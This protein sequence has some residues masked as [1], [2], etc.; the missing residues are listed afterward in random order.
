MFSKSAPIDKESKTLKA[1]F[2][3]WQEEGTK[4]AGHHL[5]FANKV[6]TDIVKP[7]ESFLKSKETERKKAIGEGQKRHKQ[8]LDAKAN[9]EKSKDVY[10]K[11]MKEAEQATEAHEKAKTDLESGPDA[12]KK[13]LTENEKKAAQK[14][15]QLTEKGKA[16]EAAY[17]KAVDTAND[18]AK[19]TFGTH[20]PPVIDS[21][22]ALEE[23]RYNL[24]KQVLETFQKEFR[25]L[26]DQLIERADELSKA[27]EAL[28]MDADLTEFVEEKKGDKTEPEVFKFVAY[29]EPAATTTTSAST[30]SDEKKE[31]EEPKGEEL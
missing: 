31:E 15:A 17:Q 12:K 27:L 20:L 10:L 14:V 19:E 5:E 29:K 9:L 24:A 26:P 22:Q 16:A 1:A 23:E 11:T 4:I 2:L 21:L 8:Y 13:Q 25:A 3:S 7:L 6:N 18:V 30:S 28:D